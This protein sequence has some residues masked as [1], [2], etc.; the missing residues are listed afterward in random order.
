MKFLIALLIT[1]SFSI[2]FAQSSEQERDR[3]SIN[4][5]F[6]SI[7]LMANTDMTCMSDEDCLMIPVG[8]RACGGPSTHILASRL[9]NNFMEIE[10][11]SQASEVKERLYNEKYG[12]M[13][14]CEISFPPR[15]LCDQ[16]LCGF[17][18]S[19]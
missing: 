4:A 9:N 17:T 2:A 19:I 11:L 16:K 15:P 5:L 3:A 10:Y 14:S 13:S 8:N 18:T 12:I 7:Q 1:T 6:K